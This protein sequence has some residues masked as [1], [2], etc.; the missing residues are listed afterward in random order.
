M[1]QSSS[2]GLFILRRGSGRISWQKGGPAP[3]APVDSIFSATLWLLH[4]LT[5]D[6]TLGTFHSHPRV[7]IT[8]QLPCGPLSFTASLTV[9]T[10]FSEEP[11]LTV[12]S[13]AS[14][15]QCQFPA[16]LEAAFPLGVPRALLCRGREGTLEHQ[17]SILK[18]IQ[19]PTGAPSSAFSCS[20][21][22][23]ARYRAVHG[24]FHSGFFGEKRLNSGFPTVNFL[25][26][27]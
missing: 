3:W 4:H 1:C 12:C 9:C 13:E 8:H 27:L 16:F 25:L 17:R 2:A 20:R 21:V 19:T 10:P 14:C 18:P 11:V 7:F 22:T 6:I 15:E 23:W 24:I 5:F 26:R